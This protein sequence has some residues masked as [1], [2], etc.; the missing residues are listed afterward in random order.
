MNERGK[1]NGLI[2]IHIICAGGWDDVV[3]AVGWGD[4]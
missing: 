2:E 3:C 4:V 1:I